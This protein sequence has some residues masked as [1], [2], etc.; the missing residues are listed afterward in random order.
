MATHL[1]G[2]HGSSKDQCIYCGSG[3]SEDE[4][5]EK[6]T[7]MELQNKENREQ[8]KKLHD[9]VALTLTK[10][11]YNAIRSAS[12]FGWEKPSS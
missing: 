1:H 10:E 7:E 2:Y 12:H 3:A 8:M 6:R 9:R 4:T 11:E 5:C